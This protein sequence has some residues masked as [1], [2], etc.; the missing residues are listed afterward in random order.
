MELS[1]MRNFAQEEKT[2]ARKLSSRRRAWKLKIRISWNAIKRTVVNTIRP[3]RRH[4]S[5]APTIKN[6][7]KMR[8]E[9]AIA[10]QPNRPITKTKPLAQLMIMPY[11]AA[12]FIDFGDHMTPTKS[13]RENISKTWKQLHGLQNWEGLLDPLDPSLRREIIKYGEFVEATYDAFDFDPLSEFCGSSRYNR[14]KFFD[15]LGLT[16]HGYKVTKYFYAM[17]HVDVPRWFERSELGRTWS[18]DSNWMGYVAVSGDKESER[19]GRR[20]IVVAWRGTV[21]PS[22]WYTD[23]KTKLKRLSKNKHMKV[24]NGFL[25][26]YRSKSEETRYNKLSASE[27]VMEE[28]NRLVNFFRDRGEEVSLTITGHSLGGAL[29]VLNAYEAATTIP[30][31]FINVISFGAPRVG[32]IAFKEKLNQLG[33]KTLRV[34]VKQ[35]LVPKLPGLFFNNILH[36]LNVINQRLNWV[37]RH[38]GTQLKL[39]VHLSPYVKRDSN[40]SG[41]HNLELYLHLLDGYLDKKSKFRWNARRDIALV[42]KSSDMLVEDLRIPEFWYQMPHKGLVL[43]KH[44]RWVKPGREPEDIPSPFVTEMPKNLLIH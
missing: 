30:G 6:L 44:G 10:N 38:V 3:H 22:E 32:N 37:Y 21:A 8:Q 19:I 36:K 13:P 9:L 31:I 29:A 14:H 12:D 4:L 33:V 26:I 40:L 25:S 39:D 43:N 5:C 23:L 7:S 27:Q 16:G 2:S 28:I 42:N 35:D 11:S 24:Q 15:E 18:K 20:D 34:V 1:P 41:S 17:S